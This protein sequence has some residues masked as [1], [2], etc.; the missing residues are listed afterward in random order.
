M[1]FNKPYQ[2]ILYGGIITEAGCSAVNKTGGWR[3]FKPVIDFEKCV[4]CM[5]CWM[6]CPDGI[7]SQKDEKILINYEYCKGCGICAN[8]CPVDAIKM[9]LEEQ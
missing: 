2:E 1:S 5:R 4:N 9:I 8:Q 3:S 6:F 7:M